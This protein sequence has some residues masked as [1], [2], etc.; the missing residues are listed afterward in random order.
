MTLREL[1]DQIGGSYDEALSRLRAEKLIGKFVVRFLDDHSCQDLFDAWSRGD[2][3]A[4]FEAA[5]AAKGVCAN[6]SLTS[7]AMPASAIT[8]ALRPGNESLRVTSDVDS[9]I[10]ELRAAYER[11]VERISSYAE[12]L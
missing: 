5:H 1:Y 10:E 11:A 6:L 2:E 12:S 3:A 7:L 4:A 9:L 8:E